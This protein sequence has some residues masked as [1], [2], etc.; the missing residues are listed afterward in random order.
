M[1]QVVISNLLLIFSFLLLIVNYIASSMAIFKI[2]KLE[3]VDNPWFAWVPVLNDYLIIKLGKGSIWFMILAVISL[4]LGGPVLSLNQRAIKTLALIIT[5][6]W[7]IYKL[8]LYTRICDR[9]EIS[10]LIFVVGFLGQLIGQLVIFA[11][12]VTIVGHIL[13][14]RSASNWIKE[15]TIIESKVI[16]TKNKKK[17]K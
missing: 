8:F 1:N 10:I 15:K 14:Y 11:V 7:V 2:A 3:Y 5:A 4:V 6:A 9:Y 17:K 16:F 12:I 13:L